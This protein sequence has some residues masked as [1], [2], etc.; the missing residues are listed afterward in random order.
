LSDYLTSD[1]LFLS[2]PFMLLLLSLRLEANKPS[3]LLDSV[4]QRPDGTALQLELT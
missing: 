3:R 1:L 4:F 2:S